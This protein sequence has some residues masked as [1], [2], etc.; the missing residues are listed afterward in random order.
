MPCPIGQPPREH[1]RLAADWAQQLSWD[2]STPG[3]AS[4]LLL[5]LALAENKSG[6]V[7]CGMHHPERIRSNAA[8]AGDP[9]P[10]QLS[11]VRDA[12]RAVLIDSR[13]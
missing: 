12:I 13:V 6:V 5:S 1:P 4:R 7:L 3:G 8:L 11:K 10:A 9:F 2:L